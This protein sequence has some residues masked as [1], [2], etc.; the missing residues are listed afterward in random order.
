[1]QQEDIMRRTAEI[2]EELERMRLG[3]EGNNPVNAVNDLRKALELQNIALSHLK[4]S[5][6][7]WRDQ[8]KY[9]MDDAARMLSDSAEKLKAAI[10]P[11]A[12][13]QGGSTKPASGYEKLVND[14]TRRLS[15]E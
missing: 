14:Y 2:L 15:Y 12:T 13:G 11:A 6:Q 4:N 8:A 5:D 7:M 9:S 3:K 1:M 10:N